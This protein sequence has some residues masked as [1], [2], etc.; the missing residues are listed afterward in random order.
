MGAH[1]AFTALVIRGS[2]R[3]KALGTPTMNLDLQSV[4]EEL[5][6][7]VY[8]VRARIA[9]GD[10]HEATMHYGPRPTFGDVVSCE[11]H[12]LTE[13]SKIRNL[14]SETNTPF[15]SAQGKK[16]EIRMTVVVVQ[17]LR[18]VK[19]FAGPEELKKQIARDIARAHEVLSSA[20]LPP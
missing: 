5:T 14:K 16:Y 12:L 13:K 15:D 2:G 1:I 20:T 19:K 9:E 18:G 11:I 6:E 8:A 10:W 7:G 17:R 4:P 3:G